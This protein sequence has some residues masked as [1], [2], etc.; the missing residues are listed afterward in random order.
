MDIK[1][2]DNV[3]GGGRKIACPHVQAW[4]LHLDQ[5]RKHRVAHTAAHF[6]NRKLR[7]Q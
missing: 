2:F 7:Q 5:Q 3:D 1:Y 6:E 4:I